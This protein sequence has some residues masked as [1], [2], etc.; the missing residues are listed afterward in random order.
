[1]TETER[2]RE[3]ARIRA[4]YAERDAAG[5]SST[6]YS[7]ANPGYHFHVQDLEWQ[8]Q[9]RLRRMGFAL[10]GASV[11]EVG[12]G[13]GQ[14]LHRLVELGASDG[15]GVD[16]SE[17]RVAAARERYPA[18]RFEV[19]DASALPFED[20]SFDL[21]T[22][23]VCLSSVLDAGL[24]AAIAREMWRVTRPGGVVLSYD[25]RPTPAP[26]RA[27]GRVLRA[28]GRL[29]S[30]E[31]GTPTVTI[32]ASEIRSLFGAEAAVHT[33]TLNFDLAFVAGRSLLAAR[34]LAA[35]PLLRTH[36]LALIRKPAQ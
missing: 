21:V 27:A 1:M 10:A 8:V 20:A 2:T 17:H 12:S 14:I 32:S 22:Q 19:A 35:L 18:L 30:A 24:R 13:F 15:T 28:A 26:L 9:S 5:A 16:L 25:L 4:A 3:A 34:L 7:Y 29:P 33:V 11:L 6:V 31:T 36:H 23:F